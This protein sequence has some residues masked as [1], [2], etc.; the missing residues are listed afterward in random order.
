M[1]KQGGMFL[2]FRRRFFEL[3]PGGKLYYSRKDGGGEAEACGII[4]LHGAT[5]SK[6]YATDPAGVLEV[7]QNTC[8]CVEVC[9]SGSESG[10][11]VL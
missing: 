1:N 11:G 2:G 4:R 10:C 5:V 6:N 8:V 3:K 9:V 7:T